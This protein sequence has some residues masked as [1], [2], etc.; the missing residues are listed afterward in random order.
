MSEPEIQVLIWRG[1]QD[2]SINHDIQG[3]PCSCRRIS[4]PCSANLGWFVTAYSL[5]WLAYIFFF[6]PRNHIWMFLDVAWTRLACFGA[7]PQL[8]IGCS[9]NWAECE[10]VHTDVHFSRL[11]FIETTPRH[12]RM[13]SCS[14]NPAVVLI[15]IGL[16]V[17]WPRCQ[18]VWKTSKNIQ[19]FT[20]LKMFDVVWRLFSLLSDNIHNWM[21]WNWG[22]NALI[23]GDQVTQVR[24][25]RFH[26][27]MH[28]ASCSNPSHCESRCSTVVKNAQKSTFEADHCCMPIFFGAESWRR[29][30][31]IAFGNSWSVGPQ[32]WR[33]VSFR[34]CS[35]KYSCE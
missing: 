5:H 11:R 13:A 15:L 12:L 33:L 32:K 34:K 35:G 24:F 3:P 16:M 31:K 23:W 1:G 4:C 10:D 2:A 19:C 26:H 7:R 30:N 14:S 28:Q 8:N 18:G 20:G 9:A 21:S 25:P 17:L 27:S 29:V 6:R 22:A